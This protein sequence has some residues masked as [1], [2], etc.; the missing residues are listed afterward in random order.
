MEDGK[1]RT[2]MDL[3]SE[4]YPSDDPNRVKHIEHLGRALDYL[5]QMKEA[6]FVWIDIGSI[7]AKSWVLV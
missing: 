2:T 5:E 7:H 1:P 6:R 4:I 3:H